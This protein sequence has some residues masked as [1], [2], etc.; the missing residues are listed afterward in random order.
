[1]CELWKEDCVLKSLS[2]PVN[3]IGALKNSGPF[4][5]SSGHVFRLSLG[6]VFGA[7]EHTKMLAWS[8]TTKTATESLM[9][10]SFSGIF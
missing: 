3:E 9:V 7:K 8:R 6:L 5:A 10:Q 1:M 2:N 4:C